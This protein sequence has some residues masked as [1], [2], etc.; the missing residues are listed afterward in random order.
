MVRLRAMSMLATLVACGAV[1]KPPEPSRRL[2]V[3]MKGETFAIDRGYRFAVLPEP[4]TNVVRLHVRYPVGSVDDPPGKE[5]LAHLVEHLLF[6][7]E[8][9]RGATKTSIGA[10]LGRAAI[11]WNA[12]THADYTSY[13][14]LAPAAALDELIQLEVERVAVGCAGLTPEIV[15]RER[16]V[17]LNELRQRQGVSGAQLEREIHE[18][19]YPADHPY[20][21]VDSVETVSKLQ[22]ED[23]CAF[24]AGP[25]LRGTAFVIASGD[26]DAASVKA[27]VGQH[28]ARLR[29]RNAAR[30]TFPPVASPRPGTS[31]IKA[32]IDEPVLLATWPLPPRMTPGGRL[33]DLVWPTIPSRIE[34]FAFMFDWGHSASATVLGGDYAP[35]LAVGITLSSLDKVEDAIDAVEKST[36]YA[37]WVLGENSTSASWVLAWEAQAME[38]LARWESLAGRNAGFGD[39]LQFENGPNFLSTRLQELSSSSPS[40]ARALAE[41]WLSPG[42]AHYIVLEPSGSPPGSSSV[43]YRGGDAEH[44][45]RVDGALADRPLPM[46]AAVQRLEVKRFELG[47][48]LRV[49]LWPHGNAP[50][51]RGRL[52]I[53]SGSAHDRCIA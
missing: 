22:L 41:E 14:V 4:G 19:V 1:L 32:D 21:R 26:V 38:L 9:A 35:V 25:Y 49:V 8:L 42:R 36:A 50:V 43:T 45:V 34:Q 30:P 51:V 2:D 15:A 5:G 18:A 6:Q 11:S 20:L 37:R 52:V 29:Q 47:N 3:H 53:D 17:V 46:R 40:Q 23:V 24:L 12:T 31:R 28:F 13:D 48:G 33:L 10:E 7:V 16:E 44:P 27:S 39:F